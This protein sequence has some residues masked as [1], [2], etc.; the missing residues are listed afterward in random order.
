RK[1]ASIGRSR[2]NPASTLDLAT[3]ADGKIKGRG[4]AGRSDGRMEQTD[5]T[6]RTRCEKT[7]QRANSRNSLNSGFGSAQF[8][9]RIM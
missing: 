3:R 9:A 6:L 5:Q 7:R 4:G 8:R 2:R 1:T